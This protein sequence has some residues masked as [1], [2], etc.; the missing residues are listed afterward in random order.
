MNAENKRLNEVSGRII[1]AAMKIS[2]PLGSGFL[3]KAYENALVHE[4]RKANLR[5]AQQHST[6]V[7]CDG[8]GSKRPIFWLR[9]RSW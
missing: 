1:G 5:V 6:S 2:N 4:L 3:E 7:H 9:T 8:V